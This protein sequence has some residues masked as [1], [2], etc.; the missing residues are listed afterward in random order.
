MIDHQDEHIK[1]V[2][3]SFTGRDM[4]EHAGMDETLYIPNCFDK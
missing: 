3:Y 2:Y 1:C 4:V